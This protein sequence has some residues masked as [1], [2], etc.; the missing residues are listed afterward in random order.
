[1][2]YWQCVIFHRDVNI[3]AFS[4]YQ[5]EWNG[6]YS[7]HEKWTCCKIVWFSPLITVIIMKIHNHDGIWKQY[8]LIMVGATLADTVYLSV[9]MSVFLILL[10]TILA[11][12]S[13]APERIKCTHLREIEKKNGKKNHRTLHKNPLWTGSFVVWRL[14]ILCYVIC[15]VVPFICLNFFFPLLCVLIFQN[16]GWYVYHTNGA[17]Q[18]LNCLTRQVVAYFRFTFLPLCIFFV[19]VCVAVVS[20]MIFGSSFVVYVVRLLVLGAVQRRWWWWCECMWIA[21]GISAIK[22][23]V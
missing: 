12:L 1:M 2:A 19:W 6:M 13:F 10:T 15:L 4:I 8:M 20:L 14:S 11:E 5:R 7:S 23:L 3:M 22:L 18:R 16:I 17:E 9:D 21:F